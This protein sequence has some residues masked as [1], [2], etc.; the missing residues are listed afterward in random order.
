MQP[1]KKGIPFVLD[2]VGMGTT[3]L[4]TRTIEQLTNSFELQLIKGNSGEI[5][6]LHGDHTVDV[7]GVDSIAGVTDPVTTV[8]DLAIKFNGR[9][10]VALSGKT[11]YVSDR[12]RIVSVPNGSERLSLL[13]G[14]GCTVTALMGCF[15]AVTK[16]YFV[17]VIDVFAVMGVCAEPA[18]K[19][20]RGQGPAN[21]QVCFLRSV[22]QA[23]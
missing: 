16:D 3:E 9:T 21:F 23:D 10:V 17:A 11:D 22:C 5:G 18:D 14:M 12:Q 6:R 13:T 15:V 8:R 20:T 2:P 4:R 19:K 1:T 7:R